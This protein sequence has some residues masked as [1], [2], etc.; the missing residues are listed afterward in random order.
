MI[1]L[2]NKNGLIHWTQKEIRIREM[3]RDYFVNEIT[4]ALYG[5]NKAWTF[6]QC[7][8][9]ILTAP[10]LLKNKLKI[11]PSNVPN[12]IDCYSAPDLYTLD[13]SPAGYRD[14]DKDLI[15]RPE[16]TQGSY[17]YADYLQKP[18]NNI[19]LPLC[20]YQYG[21]S[22]RREQDQP[23]KFMRLKEFYQLEFQC[24]YSE[25]TKCDYMAKMGECVVRIMSKVVGACMRNICE[26]I[27]AYST[28]TIDI[29][30]IEDPM[31]LCSISQRT[32]YSYGHVLEIAI[33]MDRC[34]YKFLEK[35]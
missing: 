5:L 15:L 20:V 21:K 1:N 4:E 32:D 12:G 23:T 35:E 6:H 2:S 34:V 31:E 14:I 28:E 30:S 27:P 9:P 19:K 22:F 7:E 17:Q 29:L 18:P 11:V 25:G 13:L 33:G 3:L 24:I 8:A 10:L 26:R 16:T